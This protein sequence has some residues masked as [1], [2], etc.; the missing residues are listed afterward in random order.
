MNND[1]QRQSDRSLLYERHSLKRV[2]KNETRLSLLYFCYE[3]RDDQLFIYQYISTYIPHIHLLH[4]SIFDTCV[5]GVKTKIHPMWAFIRRYLDCV[6]K[7]WKNGK[8]QTF[9]INQKPYIFR[10]DVGRPK[11]LTFLQCE[12]FTWIIGAWAIKNPFKRVLN[13]QISYVSQAR[14]VCK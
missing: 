9:A 13:V 11:N 6:S 1:K 7:G 3:S 8:L 5:L 2:S 12:L 14:R 10:L 4:R